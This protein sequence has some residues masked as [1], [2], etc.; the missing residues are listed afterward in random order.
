M[1]RKGLIGAFVSIHTSHSQRCVYIHTDGGRLCRPY[2]I[3]QKGH[4]MVEQKHIDEL[5]RGLRKFEDFL[6]D[7]LV[8]YLDVNEEN[9]S[10]IAWNENYINI[11]TT[12]LEIEPFTLL[13]VCAGIILKT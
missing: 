5:N 13:G 8:E 11:E 2:I 9:D 7:G 3:V 4:P 6:H 10:F 1:R 12:H